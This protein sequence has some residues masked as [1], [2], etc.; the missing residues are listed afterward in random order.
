MS[1]GAHEFDAAGFVRQVGMELVKNRN[2]AGLSRN[3]ISP[4]IATVVFAIARCGFCIFKAD[5]DGASAGVVSPVSV[6][7]AAFPERSQ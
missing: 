3:V 6:W 4:A 5:R 1:N 7:N 2:D